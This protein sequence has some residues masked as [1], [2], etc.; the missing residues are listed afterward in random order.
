MHASICLLVLAL[1]FPDSLP[2]CTL[3]RSYAPYTPGGYSS[4]GAGPTYGSYG[5]YAPAPPMYSSGYGGAPA[6]DAMYSTTPTSPVVGWLLC[7]WRATAL[8]R[9]AAPSR[10]S[11]TNLLFTGGYRPGGYA[12]GYG[13]YG[14]YAS[15]VP[16]AGSM[17]PA[18]ASEAP[19]VAGTSYKVPRGAR[20]IGAEKETRDGKEVI[21]DRYAVPQRHVQQ[22]GFVILY[23]TCSLRWG[24][25]R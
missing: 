9:L 10:D 6:Y 17:G 24:E 1:F 16:T 3:S 2:C 14:G 12:G 4:Y 25:R 22:V 18:A 21:I 5:A 20:Y 19:G 15:T 13:G 7:P 23:L 11:S 8:Y